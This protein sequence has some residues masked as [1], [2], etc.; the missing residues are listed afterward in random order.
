MFVKIGQNI[1]EY[2]ILQTLE[3]DSDRKRMSIVLRDESGEITMY[4]KGESLLQPQVP[5]LN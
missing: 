2:E 4:T 5:I 3:F 1:V